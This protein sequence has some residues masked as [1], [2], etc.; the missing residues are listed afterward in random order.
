MLL[1]SEKTMNIAH[2]PF[3]IHQDPLG[4]RDLPSITPG[5]DGWPAIRQALQAH[6]ERRRQ[7][8]TASGWLAIAASVVLAVVVTNR[9][10]EPTESLSPTAATQSTELASLD[11][12]QTVKSLISLSQTL[13]TQLRSLREGTGS[14]PANS[15]IY[16]AELEDL[17]FV[18][19]P[20]TGSR[21][22]PIH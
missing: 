11:N 8:R 10:T 13:E 5:E 1:P 15:A 17:A 18:P 9:Q 14:M 4:L 7:F 6:Q 3:S 12:K 22:D 2:T 16:V 19:G 21:A 20:T